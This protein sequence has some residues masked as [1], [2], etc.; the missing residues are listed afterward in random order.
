MFRRSLSRW[1]QAL[2]SKT[3][4][5]RRRSRRSFRGTSAEVLE[6]RQLLAATSTGAPDLV[7]VSLTVPSE[8][9]AAIGVSHAGTFSIANRGGDT[10][11]TLFNV[12]FVI[13]SVDG[14][15]QREDGSRT[16]PGL[17]SGGTH[18]TSFSE[19]LPSDIPNGNYLLR[20]IV[21]SGNQVSESNENN[22]TAVAYFRV[23]NSRVPD[24]VPNPQSTPTP[25]PTP[26]GRADLQ[27]YLVSGPT[28]ASLGGVIPVQTSIDNL[29][30][31]GTG[32]SY[33]VRYYL[34]TN[35]VISSADRLIGESM[36]PALS[37][38]G[39]DSWFQT[40]VLP[41]DVPLGKY[42][43]GIVINGNG[44]V[45]ESSVANNSLSSILRT[46]IQ[47]TTS[48]LPDL[49]ATA[50]WTSSTGTPGQPITVSATLAN[51]S[52]VSTGGPSR[53]EVYL[54]RDRNLDA[55][56]VRLLQ[57]TRP[58]L[59]GWSHDE[60]TRSLTLPSGLASGDY[61]VIVGGTLSQ[62][63]ETRFERNFDNNKLIS[64][65]I[66]ISSGRPDVEA[67]TVIGP[68]SAN[69]GNSITVTGNAANYG[70][71]GTAS[72]NAKWVLSTD[73]V[74]NSSDTVLKSQSR[75]GLGS[76]AIDTW[77]D[78]LSLPAGLAT[79]SYY[80]GLLIND[81]AESNDGAAT[82]IQINGLIDFQ[83]T[84][85]LSAYDGRADTVT[86]KVVNQQLQ[87]IVNN[88]IVQTAPYHLV[89][90]ILVVGSSD[91]DTIDCS[92]IDKPVVI[93]GGG[94]ND[95]LTGGLG[96]DLI[97]GGAGNDKIT[98]NGGTDALYGDAGDDVLAGSDGND[99]LDGGLG[100]DKL[101]GQAGADSLTGNVGNDTLDGG[102][103]DDRVIETADV[104]FL[105]TAKAL[106]GVG[107]DSL[108]G[109]ET[110]VLTGGNGHNK[111]DVSAFT[112]RAILSGRGGNDTLIGTNQADELSG[113]DSLDVLTGR[114]G[115]DS[116]YGGAGVD[117]VDGGLGLDIA[118]NSDPADMLTSV[119]Q[120]TPGL[121]AAVFANSSQLLSAM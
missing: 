120:T 18:S 47:A 42:Y 99:L 115:D 9:S 58:T 12:R 14:S 113:G 80:I 114:G 39:Y 98:G 65:P 103:G 107:K 27:G 76:G 28:T 102:A 111:L 25:T 74:I 59:S 104:D 100:N 60:I 19:Q 55:S 35:N 23:V 7:A 94:G 93:D 57:E 50:I 105:A 21:D 26:V 30:S 117:L 90:S 84:T 31:S 112:G 41:T 13:E 15:Y 121:I 56:D 73:S 37:G 20:M 116:L 87:A 75:S 61:Y 97:F 92:K 78:T 33:Q 71:S 54:S 77:S 2:S 11:R 63:G 43:I 46:D 4:N 38:R 88:R 52:F 109:I 95:V 24:P 81:G 83:V 96:N 8:M 51:H 6:P 64:G 85:G 66:R 17:A 36:R 72:Y 106:T 119:E 79:G 91:A 68:S 82:P 67:R 53:F 70:P 62:S 118:G 44:A 1:L 69:A 108:A 40:L 101:Q 110:L 29:G 16:I 49:A 34:S 22:N 86:L 48:D 5:S 89:R 32:Q 45:Q 10:Y 3:E